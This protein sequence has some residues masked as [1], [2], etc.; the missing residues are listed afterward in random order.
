[1]LQAINEHTLRQGNSS[2][3]RNKQR[4]LNNGKHNH[5]FSKALMRAQFCTGAGVARECECVRVHQYTMSKQSAPKQ[6]GPAADPMLHGGGRG[7]GKRRVW[8]GTPVHCEQTVRPCRE[9]SLALAQACCGNALWRPASPTPSCLHHAS[10]V[11]S[12]CP[13]A[14]VRSYTVR[15]Q[16]EGCRQRLAR[17]VE[18]RV[19]WLAMIKRLN[20]VVSGSP[21]SA[22]VRVHRYTLS[23]HNVWFS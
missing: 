13:C 10:P 3:I 9:P 17:S 19:D 2:D 21:L 5:L 11:Y 8:T 1:M 4:N 18:T 6:S 23:K 22:C 14:R 7:A 15:Q 12:A 16:S 20:V